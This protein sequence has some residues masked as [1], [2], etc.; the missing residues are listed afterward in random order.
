LKESEDKNSKNLSLQS[1][2]DC[3]VGIGMDSCII[4]VN[5][6][7]YLIQTTDFFTPLVDD[8]YLTG[9]IAACNVLSDL[10]AC[11]VSKCDNILMLLGSS[12]KFTVKERDIV[13]PLMI[14]GFNDVCLEANT[15]VRGGHTV[16]NPW[17]II[18]GVAT[19]VSK[20][21]VNPNGANIGDVILLT[22]PIG[23]QVAVNLYQWFDQKN[24]YYEKLLISYNEVELENIVNKMYN[25]ACVSMATLNMEGAKAMQ[26]FQAT[27]ATDITGFGIYGHAENLSSV[28]TNTCFYLENLP[29]LKNAEKIDAIFNKMFKL[30]KGLS[31]ETSGGLFL[32]INPKNVEKYC[33][34]LEKSTNIRPWVVGKV[35][36]K[37]DK[38]LNSENEL[39]RISKNFEILEVVL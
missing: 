1:K 2:H 12:T 11:G 33:N 13:I 31:A 4:P 18:G 34:Y 29:I 8:P 35:I 37:D 15:K 23:T 9:R 6:N 28:N 25:D 7:N 26:L 3:E 10:Y 19:S 36:S 32:T 16:V 27:S 39:A 5:D 24:K 30:L 14:K 17:P 38:N 22:K 21:F 20:N